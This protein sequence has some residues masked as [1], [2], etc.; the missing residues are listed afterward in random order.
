MTM[1]RATSRKPRK[2]RCE[3]C[4][5]RVPPYNIIHAASADGI[6]SPVCCPCLN[7][8]VA[9][10]EGLSDFHDTGFEP[11]SLVDCAGES[12]KFEFRTHLFGPGV[13]LDAF[14]VRNGYAAGYHFQVIGDPRSDLLALLGRLIRKMRRAL[15]VKH[16][17]CGELGWRISEEGVV[18]GEIHWDDAQDGPVPLLVVDGRPIAW[19]ELGRMLMT[20]EGAQFKL[21]IRDKSEEF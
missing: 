4:G 6:Y 10:A 2:V 14:E 3:R 15:A 21:E 20:F 12:H 19:D 13:A 9:H 5:Q 11:M 7:A 8:E 17:Q 18:R 1:K 16:L